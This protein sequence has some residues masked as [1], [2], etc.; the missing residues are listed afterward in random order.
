MSP[1][2]A[3]HQDVSYALGGQTASECSGP[4]DG[5]RPTAGKQHVV[6]SSYS[7]SAVKVPLT[8]ISIYDG[9]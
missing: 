8:N 3:V 4:Q 7:A 5:Q 9:V 2:A 6:Q 1:P